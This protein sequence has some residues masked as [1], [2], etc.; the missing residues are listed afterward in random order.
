[1]SDVRRNIDRIR[2]DLTFVPWGAEAWKTG[3]CRVPPVNQSRSLLTLSNTT[4]VVATIGTVKEQF[5]KL[6][7][8]KA[9]LHHYL[10]FMEVQEFQ[11]AAAVVDDLLANYDRLTCTT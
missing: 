4:T 5:D 3:L 2:K 1:M 6:Y 9:H 11:S 8:R 7:R 10:E